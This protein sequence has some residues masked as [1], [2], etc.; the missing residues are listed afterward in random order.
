[1]AVAEAPPA[2]ELVLRKTKPMA[3]PFHRHIARSKLVGTICRA[4]DQVVVYQIT[5]TVP[6]GTVLVTEETILRFE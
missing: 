1:M 4:G 5:S 3:P 6:E 2:R